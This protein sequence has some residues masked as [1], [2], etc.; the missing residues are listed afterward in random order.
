MLGNE[1]HIWLC[2]DHLGSS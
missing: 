2:L 1:H